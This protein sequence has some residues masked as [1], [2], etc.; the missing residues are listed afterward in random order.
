MIKC[1]QFK[2]LLKISITRLALLVLLT[3]PVGGAGPHRLATS[4]VDNEVPIVL[5][6]KSGPV[7]AICVCAPGGS[8]LVV[9]NKVAILLHLTLRSTLS[10]SV[11]GPRGPCTAVIHHQ[12]AISLHHDAAGAVGGIIA[13]VDLQITNEYTLI[14]ICCTFVG[15]RGPDRLALKIVDHQVSVILHVQPC[16]IAPIC[17][18]SPNWLTTMID[19][20]VAI[21]LHLTLRPVLPIGFRAPCGSVCAAVHH[22]VS[23]PLHDQIITSTLASSCPVLVVSDQLVVG[24]VPMRADDGVGWHVRGKLR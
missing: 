14:T 7:I 24:V 17:V 22:Q 1:L 4:R 15:V 23:I 19:D 8:S 20:E 6:R 5:H 11:A 3:S 13:L 12:V 21:C 16:H 10:I 9:D 2:M 18:R